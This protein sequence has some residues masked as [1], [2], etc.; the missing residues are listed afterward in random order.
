MAAQPRNSSGADNPA[1]VFTVGVDGRLALPFGALSWLAST[2]DSEVGNLWLFPR[3]WVQSL[4]I[5][6]EAE[7]GVWALADVEGRYHDTAVSQISQ[8]VRSPVEVLRD[9]EESPIQALM[10]TGM[11]FTCPVYPKHSARQRT[12]WHLTIPADLRK[13]GLLPSG[14]PQVW[15]FDEA[16]LGVLSIWRLDSWAAFIAAAS[17]G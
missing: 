13:A 15:V 2:Q 8:W 10:A 16:A 11:I 7:T 5:P 6:D 17:R 12:S 9:R 1:G 3:A 14:H 4:G